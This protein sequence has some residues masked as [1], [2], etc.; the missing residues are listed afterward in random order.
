MK[1]PIL[2][3]NELYRILT[4]QSFAGIYVVQNG[5]FRYL[6]HNAASYAGYAPEDLMGRPPADI[7]HPEDRENARRDARAMLLGKKT[8]PSEFRVLTKDGRVRWIMETIVPITWEGKPA[9]LGNSMDITERKRIEEALHDRQ[10]RFR[11]LFEVANDAIFLVENDRFIDC[12]PKT[13]EMF[14]CSR[15]QIIGQMP[16][17]FST[18]AQ[19]D[20]SDSGQRSIEKIAAALAGEPQ[21]F[22]WRH[23]RHDGTPFDTEISLSRLE[24]P[25]QQLVQAIVRDV[26]QR[27]KIERTLRESE[28]RFRTL[29]ETNKDLVFVV[30]TSGRFTYANSRFEEVLGYSP[31]DLAGKPFTFV[32]APESIPDVYLHFKKGMKGQEIPAY[33]VLLLK[34][35]GECIPIEF[36]TTT[37]RDPE[38][39]PA[40]RFGIG[41]DITQ[42]KCAE[43]RVRE[44]NQRLS[45]IINFLPDATFAVDQEGRVIA[46]NQAIE[47]MTGVKKQDMIGKGD[48]EYALPFYGMQRPMLIDLAIKPDAE[49]EIMYTFLS[50]DKDG[51]IAE[52]VSK[53][54]IPGQDTYLWIKASS[55]TDNAGNIIGG[56]ESIRDITQRKRAERA[57]S[58]NERKYRFLT[59]AMSDTVWTLDM[60]L[61][62]TYVSQSITKMLGF[63]PEERLGQ[64]AADV[65]TPESY[66]RT[67][68]IFAEEME[69]EREGKSDPNRTVTIEVE[70]Y[71]KDGHTIWAEN[72]LRSIRDHNGKLVG[73]HGV[74]RDIT[75]R[76][77]A[78]DDLRQSEERYRAIIENIGDGYYEVDLKGN[79]TFLNDSALRIIGLPRSE[80]QGMHFKSFASEEDAAVIF[81]I[82][83]E[84]YLTGTP[85]RGLSWRVVRPDGKEQHM[86]VSVSLIRDAAG[87]LN[88]FRG[89]MHDITER[90]KAEKAIQH[91][92]YHDPL[93]GLPNRLLF[94]DRF[95]Q[96][97]AHA[98]RNKEQFAIV[99]LDLDKF[100]DVNDLL[101]HDAG[102]Q[103]LRGV[104]ERLRSQMRDGDTVA[105]FGGDEFLLLLPGMKQ[106]EDLEPLG[107]KVL[108]VFQQPFAVSEQEISVHASIG[109]AVFPDDGV[110]RDT[111]VQKADF[112]MYR[113]KSVG[114]NHWTR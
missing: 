66:A 44:S 113:A 50:R 3:K 10:E 41:R 105:R 68:R 109:I 17:R 42:R 74:S 91:M 7:V 65:L 46:W 22:E 83:H 37:M 16:A 92:A 110:D 21:F 61:N 86:E 6:N 111:L 85:F 98:R 70:Y 5:K 43:E 9:I 23:C 33:E 19:P 28:E 90:R 39:K 59:E 102:D 30:D 77:H 100:K 103:L 60:D 72:S 34:K 63:T 38:G 2:E 51:I 96:I 71:H 14:Q 12:N 24:L 82:F 55:M 40:G 106:I 20:G 49:T 84:A 4:E 67:L 101:G 26:S 75:E 94:Y 93:T 76:K 11:I 54:L 97:L 89:I 56:I 25:G 15:E 31:Q 29:I 69:K 79:I 35:D 58:D 99:M 45:D 73:I 47:E 27:K 112:A 18:P 104:A 48:Y 62:T 88:G 87:R 32:I 57:L 114:G 80:V 108:Q 95:S 78:E 52:S 107:Q 81:G 53:Y 8:S 36:V 13:L 64:K 1:K